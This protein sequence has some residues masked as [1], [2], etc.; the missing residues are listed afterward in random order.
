M[1]V[2]VCVCVFVCVCVRVCAMYSVWT[3]S[4]NQTGRGRYLGRISVKETDWPRRNISKYDWLKMCELTKSNW[5]TITGF[6]DCF[7]TSQDFCTYA[8]KV[9]LGYF[10]CYGQRAVVWWHCEEAPDHVSGVSSLFNCSPA[11]LSV[12]SCLPQWP[13]T[14]GFLTLKTFELDMLMLAS[15]AGW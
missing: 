6:C 7:S 14:L 12:C 11:P 13:Q 5:F 2:C 3:K 1:C 9:V 10:C 8:G 4:K 15:W